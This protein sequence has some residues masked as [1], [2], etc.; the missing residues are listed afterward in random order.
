MCF[1]LN[2]LCIFV[3]LCEAHFAAPGYTENMCHFSNGE[4]SAVC[5]EAVMGPNIKIGSNYLA[6]TAQMTVSSTN[7]C[8][9]YTDRKENDIEKLFLPYISN[10]YLHLWNNVFPVP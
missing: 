9:V 5:S 2:I 8:L 10:N 4:R 1:S 6:Q 3:S 7:K